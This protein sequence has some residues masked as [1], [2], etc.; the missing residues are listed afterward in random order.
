MQG[1]W[2]S[3]SPE[4]LRT[5]QVRSKWNVATKY[6]IRRDGLVIVVEDNQTPLNWL[7]GRIA[8]LYP[9]YDDAVVVTIMMIPIEVNGV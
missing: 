3:W 7:V 1:F 8:Q 2:S 5:L 9:G 4:Y 6:S